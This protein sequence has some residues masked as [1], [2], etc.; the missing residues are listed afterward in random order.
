MV[1]VVACTLLACTRRCLVRVRRLR[2]VVELVS[3]LRA[4]RKEDGQ[5]NRVVMGP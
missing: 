5:D 2:S 4:W 3:G 1:V